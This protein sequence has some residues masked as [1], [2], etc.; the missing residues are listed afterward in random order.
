MESVK[1]LKQ[2]NEQRK[3]YNCIKMSSLIIFTVVLFNK[4]ELY[5]QTHGTVMGTKRALAFA[6]NLM[7]DIEK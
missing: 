4:M 5:L 6:N 1:T 7:G 2:K 3:A